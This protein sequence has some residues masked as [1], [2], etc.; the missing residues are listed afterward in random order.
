M[1]F[2]QLGPMARGD[3]E[4]AR[5][6]ATFRDRC[7]KPV[8]AAWPLAIE[9]AHTSLHADGVHIFRNIPVPYAPW[10]AWQTTRRR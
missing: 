5:M 4:M 8:I 2:F 3:L 7:A 10:A 1:I 6:V 9:M